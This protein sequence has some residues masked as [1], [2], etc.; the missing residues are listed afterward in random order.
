MPNPYVT[1]VAEITAKPGCEEE[2]KAL[3]LSVV[4]PTRKEE[5]CIQ[6][7]LHQNSKEPG[8]FV[9][10]ENW[11]T[12]EAL[13]KHAQSEHLKAMGAKAATLVGGPSKVEMYTRIA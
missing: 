7:D 8:K 10:Y 12:G 3:L 9:F 4:E 2:L 5:G 11:A 13:A 6:Y 1:V